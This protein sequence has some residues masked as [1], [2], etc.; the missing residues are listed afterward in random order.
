MNMHILYLISLRGL[1]TLRYEIG[2]KSKIKCGIYD[3]VGIFEK[4]RKYIIFQFTISSND[5][6]EAIENMQMKLMVANTSF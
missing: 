5:R 2:S 1:D 6:V 3:S 4:I